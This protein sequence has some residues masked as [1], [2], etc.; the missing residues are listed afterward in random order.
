MKSEKISVIMCTYNGETYLREQLDSIIAQ[1]YPIYELII[2]DDHSTDNTIKIIQEYTSQYSFIKL[3]IN[4]R[5]LGYNHNFLSALLK[6][7]GDAIALADQDDIWHKEKIRKQMNKLNEGYTLVFHNSFLF[8]NSLSNPTGKRYNE[9]PLISELRLT[10]KPFIPGHECCFSSKILP[11]IRSMYEQEKNIS[12]DS[13]VALT[14]FTLGEIAFLDE[15]LVYWRRHGKAASYNESQKIYDSI[16]GLIKSFSSLAQTKNRAIIKTYFRT[17]KQLPFKDAATRKVVNSLQQ[18]TW[19]L[20]NACFI[21]SKHTMAFF[22][23]SSLRYRIKATLT[24]LHLFRDGTFLV[25]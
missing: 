5:K 17:I 3:F 20:I 15:E 19:S 12:F 1:S 11:T 24:P 22:K 10:L 25:R 14:S 21:C 6:A 9:T 2:Q 4:D 18:E 13:V 7:E 8:W 16:T 23:T